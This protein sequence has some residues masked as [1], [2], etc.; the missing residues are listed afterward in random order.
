MKAFKLVCLSMLLIGVLAWAHAVSAQTLQQGEISGTVYDT[1]HSVVPKAT[2]TLSNASTGYRRSVMSD[3]SGGYVFA[4]VPP[5]TY[6]LM[7]EQ[8]NFATIT[9]KD[10]EVHV[11]GSITLDVTLPIKG[12]AQ[13]IEVS[14]TSA[15]ETPT[16]GISQ[17]LNAQNVAN[18]PLNGSDYRDLAQ[19]TPSAQV[20]PG[21][22]GGIRLGGQQSD[23]S[24]L[25][26][27]GQDSTNNFFGEFFGS[28]ET[29]NFTIPLDSVQEF[30]VV[31]NGFAPE[32]GRSTGG[33]INVV[34]KSGSNDVHGDFHYLYRGSGLTAEDALHNPSNID[35]RNEFGGAIGFPFRKDK[36][37]FFLAANIQR[38]HGP[39]VSSYCTTPATFAACEASLAATPVPSSVYGVS[40]IKGFEGTHN[41]FQNLASVLGHYDWQLTPANHFS[42]RGFYTR[43]HTS[44]FTGGRGQNEIQTSFGNTEN[45]RNSGISGVF[46]L[47]S[48]FGR[49]VNEV[50]IGISGETRPR[51]PNGGGPEVLIL[52]SGID[53][54]QRFFL[55]INGDAGKFEGQDN[56]E[57]SF[58]KH[59]MKWGGG[60]TVFTARKDAFVGWS[61]GEYEFL[62]L[63]DFQ[64]NKPFGY[65]QGFGLHGKTIFEAD[66]LF[67]TYQ[68]GLGL[69]WQDKW[70]VSS[71]LTVTY[72][73]RYDSTWNPQ[74]QSRTPGAQVYVGQGIGSKLVK[75]PQRIPNDLR[76][77]GP[78]VGMAYSLGGSAHP[79]VIR[80]AWG[81]YYAQ[82]PSI[83]LP[84]LGNDTGT[85]L[86]CFG[87]PGALP[88][89]PVFPNIFN[90]SLDANS[91]AVRAR[92]GPPG[93]NYVDP[94]F[95]NPRVSNLTVGVEHQLSRDWVV[96]AQ[97]AYVH[98]ARL[99]V[100]GFSTTQWSRNLVVDHQDQFGRSIIATAGGFPVSL[101]PTIGSANE[102]G[103]FG[104]GNYHEFVASVNKRFTRRFQLFANYTWSQNRDNSSSER[105]TD[106]FY[107][108]QDLF[109]LNLD[110]GG[111]GLDISHQFKAGYMIDLPMGF[112][113]SGTMIAHSGLAYPAYDIVDVNHDGV[114]NQFAN[115]DRPTLTVGG[116]SSLLGRYPGRQ[117]SFFVWDWRIS[118]DFAF[119]EKYHIQLL[120]DIF[121][122]TN[123]GNLYSNPDNSAFVNDQLTAIPKPGTV[124]LNG[125]KYRVLDQIGP[126]STQFAAQ[127]GFKFIF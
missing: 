89:A 112:A 101:D 66:T 58:G 43:N 36:Q 80:A 38:Q 113:L 33:L 7:A 37:F 118:K 103:S 5:G 11:G 48:V 1:S 34:T 60:V 4:Q 124:N 81:L 18:L 22:R 84:A 17:L 86:F 67:P 79:T 44:G 125:G 26:I 49:K 111:N 24:G 110:Y 25:T 51:H 50:R 42:I 83:F 55:P 88:C 74:P 54:G 9:I 14:A 115:N 109:N 68:T 6:T 92:I 52:G 116:K 10:M 59:D 3:G 45:F 16:A 108:P 105:D 21:L 63:A 106:T 119:Q 19:L 69:Y 27:D 97:Y 126:G 15:V 91:A 120:A 61:A 47:N 2:V 73:I 75:P 127:F 35:Q 114:G 32:F 40:N 31:T 64:A 65:I 13:T 41:Q 39:L 56:F 122:L 30:Q 29:K 78:R 121:N 104:H 94:K 23:Y 95:R 102:L 93:I 107:G 98:A 70:Q 53:F 77:F 12:Q 123:A 117:P 28:L 99:R 71:R 96:S 72:G 20:V 57:Y 87:A 62:T 82:T 76:Q 90:S 46:A 100:G 8:S 85:T